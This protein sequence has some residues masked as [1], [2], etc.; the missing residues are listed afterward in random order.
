MIRMLQGIDREDLETLWKLVKEKHGINRP[1]DEYERVLWGDLKVIFEPDIK[2][3]VWRNLQGYKV[4]IW[5]LFDNCGI[6]KMNIKFRGGLF[7]LKDF[8]MIIRV[9]TAQLQLLEGLMLSEMRSKT[10]QRRDKADNEIASLMDTTARHATAVSKITSSFTTT[11][12]PPPPFFNPLLQQATLTL[13]PTTSKATTSFPL[14]QDFSFV[15]KF[16][17]RVTNLEKDLSDIKQFDQQEAQDEKN[18]YIGL[19]DT[20]MRTIIKE[21]V[22]TQLPQILPQAVL[23]F[24]TPVIEKNVTESLEAAVL[25][26]SSSQPKS[27]YEAAASLFKFELTK[28]FLDKMEESKSHLRADYKKKLYDALVESY[29]TDKDLFNTYGE[30]FTLKRSRDDSDK[31]RD[32]S[33]GSDRGT[34]RRKSSKEANKSAHADEPSLT[35]DDLGA[36]QDQEFN[37]GI[38]DEQP[39]DKEVSNDDWFKKPKRPPTLNSDW[40]MRQHVDSRPP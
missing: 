38:N 25:T 9:T 30:V 39:A 33:A 16:N 35:V 36:Q 13:T 5:K 32:P 27:T 31:D 8:K 6:Q 40:N 24:A 3:D 1:V 37:T 20:S 34:K 7:G 2:S 17:E 19:V 26:R 28:I 12:P 29:N 23:D 15:F 10:Y 11:I 22:T 14:L 21:E 4:T 18:E